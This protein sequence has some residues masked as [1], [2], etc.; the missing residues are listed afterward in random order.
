VSRTRS[1]ARTPKKNSRSEHRRGAEKPWY[2]EA[3][4]ADYLERYAHRS[5]AAAKREVPFILKALK[6]KNGAQL[7]DL[8]CGAGRHTRVFAKAG[9]N[10]TGLDLSHD[11]LEAARAIPHPRARFVEADMRALPFAG[12]SFDAVVNLFT[13]FGY[14]EKE[15]DNQK[16]LSEVARVLKPGAPFLMD[17]LNVEL[18]LANLVRHSIRECGEACVDERR[19]YDPRRKRLNKISRWTCEGETCIRRESVRAYKRAE[20]H[21]M[22]RHAGLMP[23]KDFG[24]LSGAAFKAKKT[25]RLVILARNSKAGR[26]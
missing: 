19:S 23:I 13:S 11:L 24:D 1:A 6:T 9:M 17:Y 8:C 18:T 10:V 2:E 15:S 14:F 21:E 20:L 25:P 22:L 5:D 7:L 26:R 4:C 12:A 3:F 16:V